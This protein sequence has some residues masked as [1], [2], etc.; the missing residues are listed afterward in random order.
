[1]T[2]PVDDDLPQPRQP[3]FGA[4]ID[5]TKWPENWDQPFTN[6]EAE[7]FWEGCWSDA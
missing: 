3:Q 1:M 5:E 6:A 7:A 2:S 4:M